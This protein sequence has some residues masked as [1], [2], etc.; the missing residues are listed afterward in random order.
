[1]STPPAAPR[2]ET[3][4]V[5]LMIFH[6][7]LRPLGHAKYIGNGSHFSC[8]VYDQLYS[9]AREFLSERSKMFKYFLWYLS[10]NRDFPLKIT[11][12]RAEWKSSQTLLSS[13]SP[14]QDQETTRLN[15]RCENLHAV[16][17]D[18]L[19]VPKRSFKTPVQLV[20]C[21]SLDITVIS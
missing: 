12:R 2:T 16:L 10:N 14:M 21:L 18:Y 20:T 7:K 8:R 6:S 4:T 3:N 13:I 9:R 5:C 11:V 17:N 19:P 1:M 15:K